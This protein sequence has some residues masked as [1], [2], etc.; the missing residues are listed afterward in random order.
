ML[1]LYSYLISVHEDQAG[2]EDPK[3]DQDRSPPR[4]VDAKSNPDQTKQ[5][6][7]CKRQV[8]KACGS[9]TPDIHPEH[10]VQQGFHEHVEEN[11]A[12]R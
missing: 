4:G 8:S 6:E 12:K 1:L 11:Q 2:R 7:A 10:K 3:G 9:I 5:R